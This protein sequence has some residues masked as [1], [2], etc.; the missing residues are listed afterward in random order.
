MIYLKNLINNKL[1]GGTISFNKI[2][3]KGAKNENQVFDAY[4]FGR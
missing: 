2:P 3:S 4:A 1:Y